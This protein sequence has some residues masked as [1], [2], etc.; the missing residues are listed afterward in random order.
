MN[1]K[2]INKNT[3]TRR[4]FL[5]RL[6]AGSALAITGFFTFDAI[7]T[8]INDNPKNTT[9]KPELSKDIKRDFENDRLVLWGDDAKC[10]VNQTGEKV[11]ELLD[12]KHTLSRIAAK[13]SDYY[14]IKHTEAIEV[15]IASFLCQLGS[16]GFLS[17]PFYVTLYEDR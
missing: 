17:L 7:K 16:L 10:V 4:D 11:I 5:I 13:I 1:I 3:L 6:G 15:S 12:G 2:D 8:V 14:A 9:D